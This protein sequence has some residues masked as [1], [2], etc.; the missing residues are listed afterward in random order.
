MNNDIVPIE[1]K[2]TSERKARIWMMRKPV[3]QMIEALENYQLDAMYEI[4]CA[5]NILAGCQMGPKDY[6][7]E[8]IRSS[9]T[10]SDT[11]AVWQMGIIKSY[12]D[13]KKEVC[14]KTYN[15][16][17]DTC[18]YCTSA[19]EAAERNFCSKTTAMKYLRKGLDEY[20]RI[21]GWIKEQI[22]G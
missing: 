18:V 19:G 8:K 12:D 9:F 7:L 11:H 14:N 20:G 16:T 22:H 13:W 3:A 21:Q 10:A 1:R 5:A 17:W 2:L 4:Q 6:S 15:I